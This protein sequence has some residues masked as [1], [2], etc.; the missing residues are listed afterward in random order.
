MKNHWE[1][2]Q[3][4]MIILHLDKILEKYLEQAKNPWKVGWLDCNLGMQM[5]HYEVHQYDPFFTIKA[6]RWTR[7]S[8][9]SL[10]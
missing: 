7:G 6:L 10:L 5:E 9:F 3:G 8:P 1:V 2:L 4:E